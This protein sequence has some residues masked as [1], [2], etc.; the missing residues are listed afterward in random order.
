M[1]PLSLGYGLNPI[2]VLVIFVWSIFWKTIALWRAA[3]GGQRPWFIAIIL[4]NSF[5]I[6][7][8]IYLLKFSKEKFTAQDI[9]NKNF[10]P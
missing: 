10:L 7:E 3:K 2:L 8:I 6:L 9:K 1:N 4:I 5:G